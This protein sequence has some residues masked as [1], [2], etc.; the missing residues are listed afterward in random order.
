[1][2]IL[3]EFFSLQDPN[4]RFVLAG[5]ILLGISAGALGCFAILRR[6][7]LVGDAVAHSILPG[8][9]LAFIIAGGK[10][11]F[12]LILGAFVFGLLSMV[13][14][15]FISRNSRISP[16]ASIGMV[17]SVFF[18]FGVVLLTFIQSTGYI[19]QSG[20]DDFLFGQAAA[21][22][23]EDVMVFG[24]LSLLILLITILV[25]KELKLI[26]FDPSYARSIGYPVKGMEFLLAL[27]M[28]LTITA[29]IQAVGVVLMASMLIIPAAAAR[30]WT[31]SLRAMLIIAAGVGALSGVTGSFISYTAPAMP[32]GPWMVLSTALIFFLS[33]LLAPGRGEISRFIQKKKL[34][35]RVACENILKTLYAMEE[36]DGRPDRVRPWK[37][38]R[39]RR[40]LTKHR[41]KR[42][43][44]YLL[45]QQ[46][47]EYY[48]GPPEG[49]VLT[50]AGR[51]E[52]K[53]LVRVH[54][55]WEKYL[56]QQ[57]QIAEDHVHDDAESMEHLIT[58]EIEAELR[59]SLGSPELDPHKSKIPYEHERE[60]KTDN[61][62]GGS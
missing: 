57:L 7:A 36:E 39:Q 11:P 14:M 58:S 54:R 55:L 17:L 40:H 24:G 50:Q 13:A 23:G 47:I 34:S 51:R 20:L 56:N 32:T 42:V 59:R 27:L 33:F 4:I 35:Q 3:I 12:M 29:G 53:R 5:T 26:S 9:C 43:V 60:S 62:G 46:L 16:D 25:F 37:E 18:G 31:D 28:V 10:D 8:V 61:G 30:Y 22:V 45:K 19:D 38:L 52:A 44:S 41:M 2:D 21:L 1:M 48:P 6:R 49:Y 15:D